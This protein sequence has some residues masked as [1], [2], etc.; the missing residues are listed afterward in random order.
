MY[1]KRGRLM[2]LANERAVLYSHRRDENSLLFMEEFTFSANPY[3]LRLD[4]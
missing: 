4:F 2:W 1:L 3:H